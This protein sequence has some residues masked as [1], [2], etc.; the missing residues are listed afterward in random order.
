[1]TLIGLNGAIGGEMTNGFVV[2]GLDSQE[3]YDLLSERFPAEG[4]ISAQVVVETQDGALLTD[5]PQRAAISDLTTA[6]RSIEGVEVVVPPLQGQTISQSG[7]IGLFRVAYHPDYI[8]SLSMI[9]NLEETGR[10]AIGPNPV[11]RIEFGGDLFNAADQPETGLGEVLGL[12]SAVIVLLLAFGSVVA[13][14]LPIGLALFGL[15]LGIGG[16]IGLVA[17]G[18]DVPEWTP[19]MASMIGLGVGIDYALFVVTRFREGLADG[20]TVEDA[21]GRANATAGLSVIFAGGTVVIAILGL[22]MAGLP[23]MTAAAVAVSIVVGLMVVASITILPALLCWA[24]HRV[25]PKR[26]RV[27]SEIRATGEVGRWQRWGDHVAKYAWPYMLST[28]AL[29][30]AL[31]APVLDLKLGFPDQGNQPEQSTSRQ[32]YDLLAEGFGPGFNGP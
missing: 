9:E 13:M 2:P 32:A 1:M 25:N 12:I 5:A 3:A 28:L 21:A 15:A 7:T 16:V 22:A 14:G 4:G 6:F 27:P 17:I 24:G 18:M 20:L 10:G 19:N 31:T 30:I 26:R 29:L 11:L 8:P 23:F